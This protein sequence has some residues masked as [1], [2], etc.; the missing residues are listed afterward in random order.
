MVVCGGQKFSVGLTDWNQGVGDWWTFRSSRGENWT[1]AAGLLAKLRSAG[2]LFLSC[3]ACSRLLEESLVPL[4][5]SPIPQS[6][7][8]NIHSAEGSSFWTI[9]VKFSTLKDSGEKIG[10][11]R[12]VQNRLLPWDLGPYSTYKVFRKKKE[13]IY[14]CPHLKDLQPVI[15]SASKGSHSARSKCSSTKSGVFVWD[16]GRRT[17]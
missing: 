7:P 8:Q 16:F 5:L 12:I 11:T 9:C 14:F 13:S 17:N 10:V 2:S 4:H 15:D 1:C 3:T 6:R